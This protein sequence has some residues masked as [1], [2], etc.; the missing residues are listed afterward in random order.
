[1]NTSLPQPTG[2]LS[3]FLATRFFVT[4][5]GA[6]LFLVMLAVFTT[7]RPTGAS[8]LI[9]GLYSVLGEG[10]RIVTAGYGYTVGEVSRRGPYRFV[11][12]PYYL[13]T[14]MLVL[15]FL[16]AGRN[17]WVFAGCL[18]AMVPVFREEI[19]IDEKRYRR[20]FGPQFDLYR[21]QVP[22]FIPRITGVAKEKG[23]KR[24]FSVEWA[25]FKGRHRELDAVLG[26]GLGFAGLYVLK[27]W[28]SP[29]VLHVGAFAFGILL[30]VGRMVYV[31]IRR[32]VRLY[33]TSK[34][35]HGE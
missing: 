11:R 18:A 2:P 26:T 13:G 20:I 4:R 16:V 15:G 14:A 8:L 1:M 10:L 3:R 33:H 25:L 9:G 6:F 28:S 17:A 27:Q 22:A 12:H 32:P 5:Q 23:D 35:A 29:A 21:A 7:A 19:R 24:Q 31:G 34:S 30:M